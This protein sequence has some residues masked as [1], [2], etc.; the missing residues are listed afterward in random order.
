MPSYAATP[1]IFNRKYVTPK[2]DVSKRS[3]V[4]LTPPR[5]SKDGQQWVQTGTQRVQTNDP[6][7]GNTVNTLPV[8]SRAERATAPAPAAAKDPGPASAPAAPAPTGQQ[9]P[10]AL[11]SRQDALRRAE[12]FKADR[13][14]IPRVSPPDDPQSPSFYKDFQAHGRA[15]LDDYLLGRDVDQRRAELAIEEG[16]YFAKESLDRIDP[17]RMNISQPDTWKDTLDRLNQLKKMIS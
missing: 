10:A 16:A 8:W 6:K 12:Q 9:A 13:A 1:D 7:T 2:N 14:L 3:V 17:K 15:Y 11:I 4:S 5:S